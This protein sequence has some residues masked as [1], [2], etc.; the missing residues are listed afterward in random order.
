[1]TDVPGSSSA[2]TH[3]FVTYANEAKE[4]CVGVQAATLEQHGAVSEEVAAE[5][6]VGGLSASGADVAV[7]VTGI[8][9]PGGGT[10]EKPVGTVCLGVATAKGVKT[11]REC[12][13]RSRSDFKQQVSQRALELVRRTVRDQF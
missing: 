2:F 13:P 9:G 3:G 12:H 7:S 10:E 11:Y 4:S 1:M 5:M 6:A 8:A